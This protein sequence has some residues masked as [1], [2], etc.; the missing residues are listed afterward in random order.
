MKDET[1]QRSV[2]K[3]KKKKRKSPVNAHRLVKMPSKSSKTSKLSKISKEISGPKESSPIT[4]GLLLVT[5]S[6]RL[7]S[8]LYNPISDCDETFNYW[9]PT[10]YLVQGVGFQTWE[11]SPK[12]A[13]R[14]YAYLLPQKWVGDVLLQ[15]VGM[16]DTVKIFYVM[17]VCLCLQYFASEALLMRS[18]HK[19]FGN[20]TA[21]YT[22][23]FM[24]FSSGMFNSCSA[25]L[26]QQFTTSCVMLSLA[27]LMRNRVAASLAAFATACILGWPF[28]C[29]LGVC[30]AL[31]LLRREGIV[32]FVTRSVAI[33]A[34]LCGL[35]ML[36][37]K[38]YFGKWMIAPLN[39]IAYN[40]HFA[41]GDKGQNLYGVEPWYYYVLNLTSNFNLVYYLMLLCPVVTPMI[42]RLLIQ[43][44]RYCLDTCRKMK[45]ES[46]PPWSDRNVHYCMLLIVAPCWLW[47]LLFTLQPHKEERFLFVIYP[48]ICICAALVVTHHSAHA[49]APRFLVT[50]LLRIRVQY[51]LCAVFLILS[52]CRSFGQV[53][54]YRAP[55][56]VWSRINPILAQL[57]VSSLDSSHNDTPLV[58]V[59]KEWYRFP[60]SFFVRDANVQFLNTS[61]GGQLPAHF[62][63]STDFFPTKF[64]FNDQNAR[65]S[66][67]RYV[68]YTSCNVIVDLWEQND[69]AEGYDPLLFRVVD[70]YPFLHR[71]RVKFPSRAFYF[72]WLSDV[73]LKQ[74]VWAEYVILVP[75]NTV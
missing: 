7:L 45:T 31:E 69:T 22:W 47:Y 71:S 75:K 58:C 61:F 2:S 30:L 68:P 56:Q 13:L 26:P 24:T 37:D 18:V 28:A 33:G 55:L 27:L 60:T 8:A 20:T 32:W 11:Y 35:C 29:V 4:F 12:F 52:A 49:V 5:L 1:T 65:E 73:I 44:Y 10:S 57:P 23:F 54:Y 19:W 14:S 46:L 50:C 59:G 21:K 62:Y 64:P 25:Y 38:V 42:P 43:V 53:H 63:N 34:T 41:G 15:Q 40:L 16:K 39:I 70:S 17:R 9:E 74:L 66:D 6:I 48:L 36:V 72:P 3:K 51:F 67:G